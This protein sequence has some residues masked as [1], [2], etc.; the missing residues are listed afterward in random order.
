MS[1][2]MRGAGRDPLSG[3]PSARTR[4]VAFARHGETAWTGRRYAG[5]T[6]LPL[7]DRGVA[8]AAALAARVA[9]QDLLADPASVIVASP[10]RR[11]LETA[12]TVAAAVGRP[13]ETDPRWMEV[14]FG[15]MEGLTFDEA[16]LTWPEIAA[17]LLA[18]DVAI[19]WPGGETWD[20][21]RERVAAALGDVLV[22]G[23]PVLVVGHGIAIRVALTSL[24]VTGASQQETCPCCPPAGWWWAM[25]TEHGWTVVL[26]RPRARARGS[27]GLMARLEL[28]T[29]GARSGKSAFAE[30]RARELAAGRGAAAVVTY[31]ATALA[32]D[33]EM[34]ER[35]AHHRARRPAAW[36]TVEAPMEL[37][38][39]IADACTAS[40]VVLVDCL[41]VWTANHL[42]ALGDPG[43][44]DGPSPS[45][46]WRDVAGLEASLAT[47][48]AAAVDGIRAGIADVVIV[49]NEVGLGLVPPTPIGR[50]YR[51]LLGRLN[52]LLAGRADAAH[53]VVAGFALDLTTLATPIHPG[54]DHVS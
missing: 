52:Q 26:S 30:G 6:D 35:I 34:E 45:A 25:A 2:P 14:G 44:A 5:H 13:V 16:S 20:G 12:R 32:Y 8:S 22:R 53:L 51:D 43:A 50:A 24:V 27:P 18:G 23:V 21:L 33:A 40:D 17:R 7:D 11:A 54:E 41:A 42:L 4:R 28:V 15:S 38:I 48:L 29:G 46:W 39:A 10:L 1:D 19:D 49:T 36:R 9:G 37:G 3:D 31:V 47:E